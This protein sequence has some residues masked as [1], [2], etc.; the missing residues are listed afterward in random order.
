MPKSNTTT[1]NKNTTSQNPRNAKM[2]KH[3]PLDTNKNK[4]TETTGHREV[5]T[6]LQNTPQ[7]KM[8]NNIPKEMFD[9]N[10]NNTRKKETKDPDWNKNSILGHNKKNRVDYISINNAL[11]NIGESIR[12]KMLNGKRSNSSQAIQKEI[13]AK[14]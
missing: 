8:S 11:G 7:I 1:N 10:P 3:D 12:Q 14:R 13:G 4:L 2:K 6:S 9:W 5:S